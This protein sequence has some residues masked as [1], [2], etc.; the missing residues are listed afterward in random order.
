VKKKRFGIITTKCKL[1]CEECDSLQQVRSV[2]DNEIN[3]VC[4]HLRPK[5]LAL[6]PGHVS[7]ES[8]RSRTGQQCFPLTKEIHAI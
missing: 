1:L 2:D 8:L 3:L 4:G 7:I 5:I 6:K